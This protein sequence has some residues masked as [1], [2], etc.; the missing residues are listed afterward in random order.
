MSARSRPRGSPPPTAS[1][2]CAR[3]SARCR[4]AAAPRERPPLGAL[5]DRRLQ[6]ASGTCSRRRTTSSRVSRRSARARSAGAS[7]RVRRQPLQRAARPRRRRSPPRRRARP[8]RARRRGR[9]RRSP[10]R[11]SAPRGRAA[12][13]SRRRGSAAS[14]SALCSGVPP[15]TSSN[16]ARAQPDVLGRH[17]V[18]AQ[19]AAVDLD[20]ARCARRAHLVQTVVAGHYQRLRRRPAA[21]ALRRSCPGT[22]GRTRR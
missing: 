11:R 2:A 4:G 5:G 16:A 12:G 22:P 13:R 19:L 9:R 10:R 3:R 21:P 6:P 7:S 17:L 8:P 1:G 14:V 15:A 20:D 18:A